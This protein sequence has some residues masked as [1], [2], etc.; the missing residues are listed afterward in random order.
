MPTAAEIGRAV[1]DALK[2]V[3][4]IVQIDGQSLRAKN[5]TGDTLAFGGAT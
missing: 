3:A 5:S 1:A 2:T 4:L